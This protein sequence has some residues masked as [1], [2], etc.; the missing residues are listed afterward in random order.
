L[1]DQLP[2]AP[3]NLFDSG[4]LRKGAVNFDID[5]SGLKQLWLLEEDAGSYDPRAPWRA[6]STWNSSVRKA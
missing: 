6:G 3:E 1:L 2:A 4:R 5:I